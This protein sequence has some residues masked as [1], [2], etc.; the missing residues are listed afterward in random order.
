MHFLSLEDELCKKRPL[1]LGQ[2]FILIFYVYIILFWQGFTINGNPLLNSFPKVKEGFEVAFNATIHCPSTLFLHFHLH[3]IKHILHFTIMDQVLSE[4]YI[5][6]SR[7]KV[8]DIP[9]NVPDIDDLKEWNDYTS[10][11]VANL[12][13]LDYHHVIVFITMHSNSDREDLWIGEEDTGP[14]TSGQSCIV[15]YGKPEGLA[16]IMSKL[17]HAKACRPLPKVKT[18]VTESY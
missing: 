5:G 13:S 9:F 11:Q 12:S 18:P 2:C 14:V 16:Q 17:R 8:V 3:S 6:D 7:L 1:V 15:R 10:Q 4:Y